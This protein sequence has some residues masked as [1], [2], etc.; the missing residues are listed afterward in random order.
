MNTVYKSTILGLTN[1]YMKS[2]HTIC[3]NSITAIMAV[4]DSVT[5]YTHEQSHTSAVFKTNI[6]G[7]E[8]NS[9]IALFNNDDTRRAEIFN[10]A[11]CCIAV[12]YIK[13]SPYITN[14]PT[15]LM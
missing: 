2:L 3:R 7:Q 6:L 5:A 13:T 9:I 12:Y 15:L 8:N 1:L 11:N 10:F 14:M 4:M